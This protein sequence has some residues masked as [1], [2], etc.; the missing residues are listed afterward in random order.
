MKIVI[1]G[2][3]NTATVL[4]K[5]FLQ[6]GHQIL[7]IGGRNADKVATLA[8]ELN[9]IPISNLQAVS[10]E[11]EV[12]IIAVADHAIESVAN[13]LKLPGKVAAH[14]AASVSKEVLKQ[15]TRHYGVFYPLQSLRKEMDYLP[16]IPVFFDGSDSIA[17][18]TLKKLAQ[19]VA[20][21]KVSEA[22]DKTRLKLHVAAV[23]VNNFTNYLYSVAEE[24]CNREGLDFKK[25]QPLIE[26]T[27]LRTRDI[28]PAKA[29]TGPAVRQDEATIQKHLAILDNHPELK[30]LYQ[31]LS[32]GI[33]SLHQK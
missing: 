3:G 32:S 10:T 21:E 19:S 31:F 18:E 30:K 14:T 17:K 23:I 13:E 16:E 7:Q 1:I 27:A 25:L 5:K 12:Y 11:A 20:N 24:Y 4:G 33:S 9:A 15:V 6:A 28:S 2:T 8:K 26:E 22:D 29:Q